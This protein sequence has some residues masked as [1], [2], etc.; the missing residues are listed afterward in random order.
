MQDPDG[1]SAIEL[2]RRELHL[3]KHTRS[4][5]AQWMFRHHA[6]FAALLI[7]TGVNWERLAGGFEKLG[8]T[9][10]LGKPPQPDT[11]KMTWHR[12]R[13]EL[14]RQGLMAKPHRRRT[15]KP[16]IGA[17]RAPS[18]PSEAAPAP[19]PAGRF[20]PVRKREPA[21]PQEMTPEEAAQMATLRARVFGTQEE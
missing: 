1:P 17:S 8:L 10:A 13:Q 4:P 5:L 12:V 15:G 3:G 2:L 21:P 7:E 20:K 19:A 14:A 18:T 6:A 11:A 16:S 9:D